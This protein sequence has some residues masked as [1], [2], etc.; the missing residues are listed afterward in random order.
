[1]KVLVACECSGV[2][3]RAFAVMGHDAYSCDVEPADDRSPFHIQCDVREILGE[4]K[5]DLIIAHPPCTYLTVAGNKY[6]SKRD[7]LI[8]PAV[9]F[10][11]MFMNYAPKVAVE[12]PVG[13]LSTRW[14]KPDQ[15]IQP[16]EY[17]HGETKKT[18]LWLKNLPKLVP[19][20]IVE[21]REQRIWKMPPSADRS[22]LRSMTY[23]GIALAM[24]EQWG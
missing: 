24:A 22:K 10:A 8:N 12:N 11:K 20:N 21:G 18:G 6:Y 7:D 1:M 15:Y 2:V 3:R 9:E 19:T 14:R 5:W 13:R 23:P 16:W 4:V 17:G